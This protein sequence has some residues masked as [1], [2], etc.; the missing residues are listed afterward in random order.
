M[1]PLNNYNIVTKNPAVIEILSNAEKIAKSD[2]SVLLIGE[3]GVGKELFAEF[4]HRNSNRNH[5][6]L[7][8]V[9]LST[10][11][12]DLLESE[13]FGYEKG[14]FT[15]SVHEKKGLFEIADKGTIFLDDIDDF[16]LNLQP[17]LLRVLEA[18]EIKRIGAQQSLPLDIRLIASSKI[19]LR[20]MV[21]QEK[22][23]MDLFF[24]IN[25]FPIEIPPLRERADDIPILIKHYLNY[26]EPDRQ[27]EISE[28]AMNALTK[29]TWPGNVR[30]LRN[31]VQ[32]IALFA[33]GKI[34]LE[35]LPSEIRGENELESLLK[36]CS[37]CF[38]NKNMTFE[39]VMCCIESQLLAQALKS[40]DGN[41]TLAA[42]M[43]GLSLSTFR[44]K[45]K[46][47]NLD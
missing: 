12:A 22:F 43:L 11:P 38:K 3:T 39:Q 37:G 26:Y 24:R 44:D 19:D 46:K 41:R 40:S 10:L 9:A 16:P 33:N 25:V 4:I 42:R 21:A 15:G 28:G 7:V 18:K 2:C 29:Y 17:K 27:I 5:N 34:S 13:L 1:D 30:E 14:S 20:T 47:H 36:K 32:R 45:L 31:V 6:P 23:R 35:N 8:K